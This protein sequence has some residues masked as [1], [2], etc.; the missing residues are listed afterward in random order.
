[1]D[2]L[3]QI[4]TAIEDQLYQKPSGMDDWL[5]QTVHTAVKPTI[6]FGLFQAVEL[7]EDEDRLSQTSYATSKN[8]TAKLHVPSPP[9]EDP[10]FKGEPFEC[11]YCL[12]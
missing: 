2:L 5:S 3:P 6:K 12:I 7:E 1:M 11:P 8:H 10:A 4:F 9:I